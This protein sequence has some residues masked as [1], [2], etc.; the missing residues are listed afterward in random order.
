MESRLWGRPVLVIPTAVALASLVVVVY[1]NMGI[2]PSWFDELR[3]KFQ[4]RKLKIPIPLDIDRWRCKGINLFDD[5]ILYREVDIN[6]SWWDFL[7][8]VWRNRDYELYV[9]RDPKDSET[10][11]PAPLDGKPQ[12]LQMYPYARRL[13]MRN[14]DAEFHWTPCIRAARDSSGRDVVIRVVSNKSNPTM[15]LRILRYLSS[16]VLCQDPRNITIPIL[17]EQ[18]IYGLVF[19]VMPRYASSGLQTC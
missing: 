7:G 15:E 13:Y 8:S 18:E 14:R 17:D 6:N 3:L 10:F 11:V 4:A 16:S 2:W 5:A 12:T 1:Q 9:L 19:V